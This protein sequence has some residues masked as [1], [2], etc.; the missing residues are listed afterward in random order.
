MQ[1]ATEVKFEFQG[2]SITIE[3]YFRQKY[4]VQLRYVL[5]GSLLEIK[6]SGV[7][8]LGWRTMQM[9]LTNHS[10]QQKL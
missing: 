1:S 8:Q 5:Y 9:G 10:V 4:N 7:N 6:I 2:R 3:Q